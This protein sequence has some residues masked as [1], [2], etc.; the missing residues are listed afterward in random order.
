MARRKF[1]TTTE[2]QALPPTA[3]RIAAC[4]VPFRTRIPR[5]ERH[6][7]PLFPLI[8]CPELAGLN[9]TLPVA[10]ILM[11]F[12]NPLCVFIFGILI[13]TSNRPTDRNRTV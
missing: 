1:L 2:G 13:Q 7:L 3:F 10:V 11:R 12:F 6:R 4:T 9:F 5:M 8:R